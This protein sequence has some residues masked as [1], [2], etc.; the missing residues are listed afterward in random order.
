M[1]HSNEPVLHL[2]SPNPVPWRAFLQPFSEAMDVPLVPYA[3]WLE[4]MENSLK[5][6]SVSETELVARNPGLKL[7]SF[8]R[9]ATFDEGDEPLGVVRLDTTKST[10]AAASLSKVKVGAYWVEK[11]VKAWRRSGFLS[12]SEHVKERKGQQS[13]MM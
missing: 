5:D 6:N 8:Y 11:W 7:L 4:A 10:K 9:G 3:T 1:R 13:S 2:V 12:K